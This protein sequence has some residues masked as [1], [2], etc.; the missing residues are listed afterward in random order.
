VL[1]DLFIRTLFKNRD[2]DREG[3]PLKSRKARNKGAG[4]CG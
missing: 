2:E 4:A 1:R 3:N